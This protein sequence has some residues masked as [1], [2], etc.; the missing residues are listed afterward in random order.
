[1]HETITSEIFQVGGP[2]LTS[3][4]DAA[5]YLVHIN[6]KAALIDAGCG[7]DPRPLIE[8]I[9]SCG[10]LPEQIQ[11]LLITHCHIDHTGGASKL[12]EMT[13]CKTVAHELDAVYLEAGDDTVTAAKWYGRHIEALT[14]DTKLSGPEETLYLGDRPITAIHIPGHSPGSVIYQMR[15]D[16]QN[17]I[18]A[19]DVHGPL[20]PILKSDQND[21]VK[22]LKQM[23]GL[24]ADI[25]CEGH[26]GIYRGKDE[27]RRFIASFL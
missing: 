18:F 4:D 16:G 25:L 10:V 1:M 17:V 24:E 11:Y 15:S 23:I 12:K 3:N 21:Y 14:V 26:F 13:G 22:S 8:N 27:V 7:G 5:I 9:R 19:Q 6:G 20:H 2:F